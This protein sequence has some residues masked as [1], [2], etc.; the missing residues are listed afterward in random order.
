MPAP[1]LKNHRGKNVSA[2]H[3]LRR[4]LWL[5]PLAILWRQLCY[6]ALIPLIL[7]GS[8]PHLAAKSNTCRIIPGDD[9]KWVIPTPKGTHKVLPFKLVLHSGWNPRNLYMLVDLF[10]RSAGTMKVGGVLGMVRYNPVLS[11]GI[12]SKQTTEW[13]NMMHVKFTW[14]YAKMWSSVRPSWRLPGSNSG[15]N[16]FSHIRREGTLKNNT[17]IKEKYYV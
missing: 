10:P 3:S 16:L 9:L 6:L 2:A 15:V 13:P 12:S 14:I 8:T 11:N 7:F 17:P 1:I 4:G 5:P